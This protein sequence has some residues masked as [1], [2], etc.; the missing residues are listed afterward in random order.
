MKI[1]LLCCCHLPWNTYSLCQSLPRIHFRN[2]MLPSMPSSYKTF[3]K[4]MACFSFSGNR[5]WGGPAFYNY[6]NAL[7]HFLFFPPFLA[8]F[9]F[10]CWTHFFC[11][12]PSQVLH[13]EWEFFI[14][15]LLIFFII[16]EKVGVT[17]NARFF[18]PFVEPF[19]LLLFSPFHESSS[20]Q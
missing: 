9:L 15:I 4:W 18:F 1:P 2:P 13:K 7:Y 10:Y 12:Q 14:I 19:L 6:S 11:V 17:L 5:Q 8:I 16:S 20:Y 3:L